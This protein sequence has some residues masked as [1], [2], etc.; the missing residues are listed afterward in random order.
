MNGMS[1]FEG[2]S[3]YLEPRV[4]AS[5]ARFR[6]AIIRF[7][8]DYPSLPS[9]I[10]QF[11]LDGGLNVTTYTEFGGGE[12]PNYSDAN[13]LSALAAFVSEL[14]ARYDGDPRVGFVQVGFLGFWGEWHT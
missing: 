5:A 7:Y 10:P 1:S 8:I 9:K 13:L 11:L 2:L 12:S 14:G 4:A 6:H 3:T